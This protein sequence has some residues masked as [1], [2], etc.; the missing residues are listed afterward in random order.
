MMKFDIDK[1]IIK[2]EW[3]IE[4]SGF[5]GINNENPQIRIV[6]NGTIE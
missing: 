1:I 2:M 6:I 5:C 4:T 3:R